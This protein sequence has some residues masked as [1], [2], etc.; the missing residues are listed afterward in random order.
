VS[1]ASVVQARLVGA[2]FVDRG[3]L[4]PEQLERALE[5]QAERGELL[6]EVLVAEFGISRVEL[7]SVLAEQWAELEQHPE[8]SGD[9]D[10]AVGSETPD[11]VPPAERRRIGEIFV[12]RGFVT[13]TDL[14]WALE[15][16]KESGKPIGEL[17][18]ERGR[19]SRLD[20]ASALAEQWSGLEKLRPPAPKR[21]EGWQQL[22]PI[23]HAAAAAQ[24]ASRPEGNG[25]AP[26][27]ALA[28]A[29]FALGERIAAI[30]TGSVTPE[31]LDGLRTAADALTSRLDDLEARP[32]DTSW[33]DELST[34]A[35]TLATRLDDLGSRSDEAAT[36]TRSGLDGALEALSDVQRRLDELDAAQ[37]S[38]GQEHEEVANLAS[39]LERT[40]TA[41][42]RIAQ[43]I[44]VVEQRDMAAPWR[45]EL[46]QLAADLGRR[47]D[48]LVPRLDVAVASASD[49]DSAALET[50][51]GDAVAAVERL[52]D[53]LQ[54]MEERAAATPWRPE[55]DDLRARVD[56]QP[57]AEGLTERLAALE[58]DASEQ[59]WR[60]E[61]E[62][63]AADVERRLDDLVAR[64]DVAVAS[65]SDTDSAA[66][67]TRLG[68]AAAAV[69]R[70]GDRLRQVED[71]AAASP[72]RD[73]L[74]DL[75]A[76]V[77]A[78]PAAGLSERLAAL[79]ASA[80]EYPWR[81]ELQRLAVE[82]GHRL[83][84]VSASLAEV[85]QSRHDGDSAALETRLADA[86]AAVER[87]SER[88]QQVE[89]R[90]SASPWRTEL[91]DLRARIDAQPAVE[92]LSERLAALEASASEHPW[93]DDLRQHADDVRTRLDELSAR[94]ADTYAPGS[95]ELQTLRDSVA[96]LTERAHRLEETTAAAHHDHGEI[97]SLAARLDEFAAAAKTD[98]LIDRV[99]EVEAERRPWR[100][101][102]RSLESRLEDLGIE[103]A[104]ASSGETLTAL[105]GELEAIRHDAARTQVGIEDRLADLGS[106]LEGVTQLAE[107]AAE[108]AGASTVA[109]AGI[110]QL[111]S[112]V[113]ELRA[114]AAEAA[115]KADKAQ[116]HG[117]EMSA[118]AR[119]A[120]DQ[121]HGRID[122]LAAGLQHDL[123][124]ANGRVD[125]LGET[126]DG[127]GHDL[128]RGDDLR[129]A[130]DASQA[131]VSERLAT[132]D[133]AMAEIRQR[134]DEAV[135]A[136]GVLADRLAALE[137][138]LETTDARLME[139]L[140]PYD[141]AI[142]VLRR[143]VEEVAAADG[144]LT[145]RLAAIEN[146]AGAR[147][148]ER[149]A[150]LQA[151]AATVH[152]ALEGI[153]ARL[154]G[155]ERQ[156]WSNPDAIEVLQGELA[157]LAERLSS[158]EA[159]VSAASGWEDA[160]MALDSRLH[161][162]EETLATPDRSV[163][164]RLDELERRLE[165]EASQA[166]ER[167]RA[168]E[169][170][171][172]KGLTALG[173]RLAETEAAYSDAG[174]ALRR[175][176][177]RLGRA[178]V[179]TDA[180]IASRDEQPERIAVDVGSYVAFVP[181]ADGY[182]LVPV[183]GSAP[184]VGDVVELDEHEQSLVVT[185]IGVS[186]IPLDERPCVYLEDLHADRSS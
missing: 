28:D 110:R 101:D 181:T 99:A 9:G 164:T 44:T 64:L 180:Q 10:D 59:V 93:R 165:A 69:E 155:V 7:A 124:A 32:P 27:P 36:T 130:L 77:D 170:A 96:A 81:E 30:E 183:D 63:L 184:G 52:G 160:T 6:G 109:S 121:L 19:L 115:T 26:D 173:Q 57:A 167:T 172:K 132:Y 161:L 154:S 104:R 89:E 138:G 128:V 142:V 117:S 156:T 163:E 182:R 175:S 118:A 100:E 21:V 72:R 177:E 35:E 114:A 137:T 5:L 143:R 17:L 178:I 158:A 162:I 107:A 103:I 47:L 60:P 2:L 151:D 74:D 80:S 125:A 82:L 1:D 174:N 53:R 134:A 119:A 16:Q 141:E 78:Q 22:A 186:P 56:A 145:E 129:H 50:R 62:R 73:E 91:D 113:D 85:G 13:E 108:E 51:L 146:E 79:E 97:A 46:E 68:D 133:E 38:A 40:G 176:I 42:E 11:S 116:A 150:A 98:A 70:L 153:A 112:M 106:R 25:A 179:E 185:R 54:E 127:I 168:T 34:M 83:D 75:R 33:R 48:D 88:L 4:T 159:V 61:F 169:R 131:P 147:F 45:E 94:T 105:R 111:E 139:R 67:E 126:V 76:R 15:A 157:G 29:V 23:E 152:E 149:F 66:L 3:L 12:E 136:E 37:A 92:G 39:R 31:Q 135:A 24:A 49:T 166:D 14:A 90:S 140:A 71:R 43:R 95:H 122:D 86:V 20:L 18:I 102:L 84:S 87:L 55:L 65:A 144:V 123:A 148:D 41:L 8:P 120:L 171:L 58:A